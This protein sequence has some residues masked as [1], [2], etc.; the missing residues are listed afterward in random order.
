MPPNFEPQFGFSPNDPSF[1]FSPNAPAFGSVSLTPVSIWY[2][3]APLGFIHF[4]TNNV[5]CWC[6]F[7]RYFLC[8]I[9]F[10]GRGSYSKGSYTSLQPQ[11]LLGLRN[12]DIYH[13]VKD[14]VAEVHGDY[15][16]GAVLGGLHGETYV[17]TRFIKHEIY[18][19]EYVGIQSISLCK[20]YNFFSFLS[21]K[22]KS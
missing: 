13:A 20:V 22:S 10:V 15:G 19:I 11:T 5:I 18:V 21:M 2:W 4:K 14:A 12:R 1:L 3:S 16:V 17:L 7:C 6:L 8:E 9:V